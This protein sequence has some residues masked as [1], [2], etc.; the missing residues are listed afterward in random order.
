MEFDI[1]YEYAIICGWFSVIV[2]NALDAFRSPEKVSQFN[3]E[4]DAEWRRLQQP[5][6]LSQHNQNSVA[7]AALPRRWHSF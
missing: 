6:Q 4:V 5:P 3:S 2:V 1:N 7:S